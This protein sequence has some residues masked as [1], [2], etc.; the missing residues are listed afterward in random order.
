MSEK[1]IHEAG[2]GNHDL[3]GCADRLSGCRQKMKFLAASITNTL[4]GEAL[5]EDEV[6]GL[7]FVMDGIEA[8]IGNV[9]D[10]LMKI[11]HTKAVA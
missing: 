7:T 5:S 11:I 8:E 2:S 6:T 9:V 3:L 4:T 10:Q 1:K